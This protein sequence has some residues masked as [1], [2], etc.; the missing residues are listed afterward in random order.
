MLLNAVYLIDQ[1][2]PRWR[3]KFLSMFL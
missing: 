2:R 3:L 1:D